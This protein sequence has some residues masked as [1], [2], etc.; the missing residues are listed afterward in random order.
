M[1]RFLETGSELLLKTPTADIITVAAQIR[2]ISV[3]VVLCL[4]EALKRSLSLR[5]KSCPVSATVFMNCQ[6]KST[7]K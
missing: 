5:L 1:D 3:V 6:Q 4:G 7:K 2:K